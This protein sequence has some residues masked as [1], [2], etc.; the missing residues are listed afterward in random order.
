MTILIRVI[1][2]KYTKEMM[3]LSIHFSFLFTIFMKK[4]ENFFLSKICTL[5][6]SFDLNNYISLYFYQNRIKYNKQKME[7]ELQYEG[8][9][10]DNGDT[11]IVAERIG[12]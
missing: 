5:Y 6:T 9:A 7:Q 4:K 10:I 12:P 2:I 8:V 1:K 3:K 11:M